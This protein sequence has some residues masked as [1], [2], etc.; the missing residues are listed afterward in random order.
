MTSPATV[1]DAWRCVQPYWGL[2]TR[3]SDRLIQPSPR[4]V[5]AHHPTPSHKYLLLLHCSRGMEPFPSSPATVR[6][7]R[8]SLSQ[9]ARKHPRVVACGLSTLLLGAVSVAVLLSNTGLAFASMIP[10]MSGIQ[11]IDDVLP[12]DASS[13]GIGLALVPV[14]VDL[15]SF[16]M[17]LNWWPTGC[18]QIHNHP[19]PEWNSTSSG[20]ELL[21]AGCGQTPD[22]LTIWVDSGPYFTWNA[23]NVLTHPDDRYAVGFT[24]E[25]TFDTT[26]NFTWM[27]VKE[28]LAF[29]HQHSVT[30]WYPFDTYT[31]STTIEAFSSDEDSSA[32]LIYFLHLHGCVSGYHLS[33]ERI[34]H[35]RTP[36]SDRAIHVVFSIRRCMCVK[37]FA[38]TLFLTN[39]VLAAAMVWVAVCAHFGRSIPESSIPES[40]LFLPLTNILLLPSLRSA[41]PGVPDF[42][43]FMDLFG[44]YPNIVAVVFSALC[45]FLKIIRARARAPTCNNVKDDVERSLA[46]LKPQPMCSRHPTFVS[47]RRGTVNKAR[48][49]IKLEQQSI[50]ST[51]QAN[52]P[53]VDAQ[54]HDHSKVL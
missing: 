53:R 27:S 32:L 40:A 12:A 42:G 41:M 51:T 24:P 23:S 21:K 1:K 49:M 46:P 43:I 39:Y 26:H 9:F 25:E 50:P 45:M 14:N 8:S 18:N 5:T 38:L 30:A 37:L 6:A 20:E 16:S 48:K 44:Y 15:A 28:T 11:F 19:P 2:R 31:A 7:I 22:S 4:S 3:S 33:I 17:T 47:V 29:R 34:Q 10:V 52:G 35:V 13:P 54:A 36:R